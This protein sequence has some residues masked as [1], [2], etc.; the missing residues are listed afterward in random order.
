MYDQPKANIL[1]RAKN[2]ITLHPDDP[3]YQAITIRDGFISAVSEDAHGLDHCAGPD[4]IVIDKRDSTVLPAF[5]D[6]HTHLAIAGVSHFDV[7]VHTATNIDEILS[8]LGKRASEEEPGTWITTTWNWLEHNIKE[9]RLPTAQELDGVSTKHPIVVRRGGHNLV[10]NSLALEL[11]GITAATPSPPGGKIGRGDDGQLN[12]HLRDSGMAG[13]MRVMPAPD[14]DK[15][16]S[17]L[18]HASASYAATGIGCVRDC[19]VAIDQLSIFKQTHDKGKLHVRVRALVHT[20]G[21]NT[22]AQVAEL[23]DK[24]EKWRHL[25]FD[26]WLSVWGIKFIFDGGIEA[27]ATEEPY[28][29]R[30]DEGCCG[31]DVGDYSGT[32]LWDVDELFKAMDLVVRR[33]WRIGT[34]A[35]GDRAIRL[36]LD[37]YER[38][39]RGHPH[40]PPNTLVMEHGGFVTADQ[41]LRA[42]NLNIPCTIQHPLLHDVAAVEM[43]YVGEERVARCFPARGWLDAG[44]LVTGGSDYPVGLYGAMRSLWGMNTRQTVAGIMG[45]E[46]AISVQEGVAMHTTL[47]AKL[48]RETDTRGTIAPG[49]FADLTIWPRN[50]MAIQDPNYLRDLLP[51]CTIVGGLVKHRL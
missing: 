45:P 13:V 9:Q 39:L 37:V 38:L 28:I 35:F 29:G 25:Q 51:S 46:H 41:R 40:L 36:L 15:R 20:M 42:I 7:P 4:T 23:L 19:A 21:M 12:G 10:A 49:R 24:M 26:P 43:V 33:G 44:G 47:A 3:T 34:H 17:G 22:V 32:L 6:T 2:V 8:M 14:I 50:P 16:I 18:E 1:I 27:N 5:D 31:S 11:G 30:P 48:L